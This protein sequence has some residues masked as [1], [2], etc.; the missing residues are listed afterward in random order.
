M[1][2]MLGRSNGPSTG[3]VA[4]DADFSIGIVYMPN[5]GKL[6]AHSGL[7]NLMDEPSSRLL[8]LP[9]N[10]AGRIQAAGRGELRSAG[11]ELGK[12]DKRMTCAGRPPAE[13]DRPV[14]PRRPIHAA[15]KSGA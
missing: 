14:R 4:A 11:L 10:A 5:G 7:G 2:Q 3:L 9:C 13:R 1:K 6:E 15:S 8:I 12:S